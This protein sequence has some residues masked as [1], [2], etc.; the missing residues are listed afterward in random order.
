M[1]CERKGP[2]RSRNAAD[3]GVLPGN[4]PAENTRNL[5]ALLDEGGEIA[6]EEPGEYGIDDMLVIR[7]GTAL[8]FGKGTALRRESDRGGAL[9]NR[10]ALTGETDSDI[11]VEGLRLI[12][13][14]CNGTVAEVVPGLRGQL[15][16]YR[17]KNLTLRDVA[18][19]DLPKI[20]FFIHLSNWEN[21]L[22]DGI[23]V[24][25][26]K[27][28]L[29]VNRGAHLRVVNGLFRT[30][31]DPIALNAHDYPSACPE[32]GWISDVVIE[33][34]V[35]LPE[36]S[37]VGFFARL[38]GGAWSGWR[39]GNLYRHSDAVVA[40]N[41]NV[42][43]CIA[44][45]DLMEYRSECEPCHD[46][47]DRAYPDGLV[48]RYIQHDAACDCGCENVVFRDIILKKTRPV[49][50]SLHYDDDAYSR[51]CYPGAIAA[52]QRNILFD[53]LVCDGASFKILAHAKTPVDTLRVVNSTLRAE[54][55]VN[56]SDSVFAEAGEN[57]LTRVGLANNVI[58]LPEG[59]EGV[60]AV[61]AGQGRRALLNV[62][63]TIKTG[64]FPLLVEGDARRT[65]DDALNPRR[66]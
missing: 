11:L 43:R 34:C 13:N 33:H 12:C 45:Q 26:L 58:L 38:L 4:A 54:T 25:G 36:D 32:F 37:S 20:S 8:R 27:D 52:P 9:I 15:N 53:R 42:Y 60:T 48:W 10:G 5:Q 29:H 40:P 59:A 3:F 66:S 57:R 56:L 55:V 7:G 44:R 17:V 41:G 31:D 39:R 21:V 1:S 47:G 6:V 46:R 51:S 19:P 2:L 50:F 62:N 35:D 24:A 18:C 16:F 49:A 28:G 64:A 22:V 63:G 30:F 65:D 14:G 61:R 23:E